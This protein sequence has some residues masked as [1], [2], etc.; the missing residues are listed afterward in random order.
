[1]S[2]DG[3]EKIGDI[4][5]GMQEIM[6]NNVSVFRERSGLS[7]ALEQIRKLK[8]R[9]EHI[10]LKDKGHCF[11]RELLDA[12]ELGHMLDLA[13]VIV[14]GALYREES[15]GAHFREDFPDRDDEKFLVHT[16]VRHSEDGPQILEKPV[17]ITRFQ[18]KERKY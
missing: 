2:A 8:Q 14:T 5:T 11:N 13:E 4:M 3:K 17:T 16:L 6:M 9:Y 10:Y 15:R 12:V 18:P 1:M 7:E